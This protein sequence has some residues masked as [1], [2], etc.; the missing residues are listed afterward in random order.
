MRSVLC[1]I[2][3]AFEVALVVRALLSWFPLQPGGVMARV[4]NFLTTITE[5]VLGPVRRALPRAGMFD[6]S[7]IVVLLTLE[8]VIRGLI[9]QCYSA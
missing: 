2:V 7:F 6:L 4:S 8:I 1:Q 9:L 3:L 5:P